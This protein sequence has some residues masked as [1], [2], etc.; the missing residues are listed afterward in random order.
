MVSCECLFQLTQANTTHSALPAAARKTERYPT[1][2]EKM[3]AA[4]LKMKAT[5]SKAAVPVY[6]VPVGFS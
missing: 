5:M 6:W 1:G 4:G 2:R 3:S